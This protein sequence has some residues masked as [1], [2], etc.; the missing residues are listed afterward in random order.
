MSLRE[1]ARRL[2]RHH[3]TVSRELQRNG[4][5]DPGWVY[6]HM[7]A[8]AKAIKRRHVARHHRRRGN[9]RLYQYVLDRLEAHWSPQMIAGRLHLDYPHDPSMR[10]SPEA[11]YRWLYLDAKEGGEWYSALAF[12]HRRRR[13]QRRYGSLRGLIPGRVAIGERP[14]VVGTRA[15]FGDWEGDTLYGSRTR[16]CLLTSVER[17]SRYLFAARLPDRRA[18]SVAERHSEQFKSLPKT[19]RRTLT[20]DNGKEFAAF[21]LI[22]QETKLRVFFADP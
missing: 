4:R 14:R 15:R 2:N 9:D 13:K 11:I 17:K 20:L 18:R 21:K 3:S 16:N 5:H 6:W 22:E 12:H 10:I 8:E 1:I 19:W 7:A